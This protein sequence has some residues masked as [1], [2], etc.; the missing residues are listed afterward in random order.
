MERFA[1]K[2]VNYFGKTLLLRFLREFWIRLFVILDT[3]LPSTDE[4]TNYNHVALEK[5]RN[6]NHVHEIWTNRTFSDDTIII[7]SL[8][9]EKKE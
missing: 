4:I 7:K 2:T 3:Y 6:S 1:K 8:D 5:D 9:I